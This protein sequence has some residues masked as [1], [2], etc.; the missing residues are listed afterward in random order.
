[1]SKR[2]FEQLAAWGRSGPMDP[3]ELREFLLRMKQTC[4]WTTNNEQAFFDERRFSARWVASGQ[5]VY[6]LTHGMAAMFAITTSPPMDWQHAPH[7][8]F[9]IKVPRRF[10]P[11]AGTIEP[12]HTYIY[13]TRERTLL[14]A[15]Y[16]STAIMYVE[17]GD[18]VPRDVLECSDPSALSKLASDAALKLSGDTARE[19]MISRIK[20]VNPE[21]L[22]E[23]L[24]AHAEAGLQ[25]RQEELHRIA[26]N[27][28]TLDVRTIGQKVLVNR[29]VSNVLAY[30][31]EQ[32]ISSHPT[33]RKGGQNFPYYE[34][35][36]PPPEVIIDR[37]FRDAAGA[38]VS[39]IVEGSIIGLRRALA[40]HVRGHWRD[41]A[42]GTGRT[43][44]KRIWI[45]PHRRGDEA[46]GSVVR[47]IEHLHVPTNLN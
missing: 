44:R 8:A 25:H 47:R 10:L 37:A 1:M 19:E 42:C 30:V 33:S 9:V 7:D 31:T 4:G 41:Q 3:E 28:K 2:L 29:F 6:D 38:A 16:D 27:A 32:R 23:E 5:I 39:S 43:Q 34:I 17:Y 26:E 46:L 20:G 18:I 12:E 15:D 21:L 36:Q 11:V 14:V 35:L 22:E 40:H 13:A 24:R 45:M